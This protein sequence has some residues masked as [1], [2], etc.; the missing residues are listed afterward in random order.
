M[1]LKT[2]RKFMKNS[3]LKVEETS[4]YHEDGI[5]ALAV[6]NVAFSDDCESKTM[7]RR[8]WLA[9]GGATLLASC[10]RKKGT[11]SLV[12]AWVAAAIERSNSAFDFLSSPPIRAIPLDSAPA[13]I[14][15]G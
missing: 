3:L 13:A 10:G 8:H 6:Q 2:D 9:A 4:G 11:V 7:T 5:W 15:P 12:S 1:R 14:V